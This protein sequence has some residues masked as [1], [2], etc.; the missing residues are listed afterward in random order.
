MC[1]ISLQRQKAEGTSNADFSQKLKL[2]SL[3]FCP[4]M[5]ALGHAEAPPLWVGRVRQKDETPIRQ[6]HCQQPLTGHQSLSQTIWMIYKLYF[7]HNLIFSWL[8]P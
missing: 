5:E 6:S 3:R 4:W 8:S 1:F 7:H 2:R